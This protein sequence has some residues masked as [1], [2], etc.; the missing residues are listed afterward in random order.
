MSVLD[1]WPK[2]GQ[3]RSRCVR[4]GVGPQRIAPTWLATCLASGVLSTLLAP[5]AQAQRL[6]PQE[7]LKPGELLY[8]IPELQSQ[9]GTL[10]GTILLRDE[11]RRLSDGSGDCAQVFLRFF[12]GVN[13][14][15]PPVTPG[16]PPSPPPGKYTDPVPG[17]TLRARVGDLVQLTFLNQVNPLDFG[18]TIDR[19]DNAGACDQSSAGS[20]GVAA[21]GYPANVSDSFPN[22]FHGSSTGNI[23]FHGT[24]TNPN[25]TGDNVFLQVRPSPR[26]DGQPVVTAESVAPSF[27]KFF[28][29]CQ[30]QLTANIRSEWP[31]TWN[32]LPAAFTQEQERL[33]K[34]YDTGTPPY[35]PPAKPAAQQVWSTNQQQIDGGLWPQF[36]AGA[37]PY[38]FRLPEYTAATWPAA[39]SPVKMGQAPGTHWY[40]AHKHGS[41]ALN[42]SNGMT[43]AFIIE[44]KYDDDLNAFYGAVGNSPWTRAQPVLVINQ[45]GGNSNL[46]RNAQ[47]TSQPLSVNGKL[48]PQ[49]SMRPGEVQLW[50]IV[51]TS[52]R[53]SAFFIGPPQLDSNSKQVDPKTGFEWR[54]IAQDGVQFADV[55]Y[56]SS[57]NKPVMIAPGNRADLLVKAP[58]NPKTDPYDVQVQPNVS[59]ASLDSP[60]PLVSVVVSGTPPENPNQQRFIP[61]APLQ[62]PFLADVTDDEVRYTARRTIVFDSKAQRAPHQHTLNGEQFKETGI[63]VTTFL[64]TAEEWKVVNTTVN[65]G[66]IDHPFHIHINPFQI[67]EVFNPNEQIP[68]PNDPGKSLAKYVTSTPAFPQLQCQLNLNDPDTWKDCHNIQQGHG[69]WWDVF[70]IPTAKSMKP[71]GGG[72]AVTVP[73]FFRMRSRFVDF[74]GLWVIH[75]HILAH[76]DRGMMTIV[77]VMPAA[78]APMRH[79]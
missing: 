20:G 79:H 47:L 4:A 33:L 30:A 51:N 2:V 18:N 19:G 17:P 27:D 70:P 6:L 73:G 63:G 45:L 66:Q 22:C 39:D 64:N 11:L 72:T 55:N 58:S 5:S 24:H 62:P 46:V 28:A 74:P 29:D 65:A 48:A 44:G 15:P 59:R 32:D 60:V 35:L 9:N 7:C 26:V 34:A 42:V 49:L 57:H 41:T 69:I 52:S 75:C 31:H 67:V 12:E 14:V 76:E 40:H 56:Q 21:S 38:C 37:F 23:H 54:Q 53:S 50:R 36:Y 61:K 3:E 8:R 13:A 78:Q 1:A 77:Q 71:P 16:G 25:S 10:R 68:D 43:G